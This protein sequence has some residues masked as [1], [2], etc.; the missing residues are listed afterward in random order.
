VGLVLTL[1]KIADPK[2]KNG[3]DKSLTKQVTGNKPRP[4][5]TGSGI[6]S[7]HQIGVLR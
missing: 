6:G 1:S 7:E 5:K 2:S 4:T 3:K